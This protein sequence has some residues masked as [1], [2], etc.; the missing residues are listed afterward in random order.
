MM[1]LVMVDSGIVEA[2][3]EKNGRGRVLILIIQLVAQ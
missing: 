3:S 1:D 2:S